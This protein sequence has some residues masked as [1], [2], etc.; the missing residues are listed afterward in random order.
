M[1]TEEQ[2]KGRMTRR[3]KRILKEVALVCLFVL[4]CAGLVYGS[5]YLVDERLARLEERIEQDFAQQLEAEMSKVRAENETAL[6]ALNDRVLALRQDVETMGA[7]LDN[8]DESLSES[9]D[10]SRELGQ[11]IEDL[12]RQLKALEESL[13]ILGQRP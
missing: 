13:E 3:E 9:S 8:A 6:G 5:L 4:L 7:V 11:R 1:Q 10:T 2:R 12:D